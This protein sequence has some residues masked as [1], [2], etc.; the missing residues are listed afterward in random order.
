MMKVMKKIFALI[1]AML[2][3]FSSAALA[4]EI[5]FLGIPWRSSGESVTEIMAAMMPGEAPAG[6]FDAGYDPDGAWFA[7][8]G[9]EVHNVPVYMLEYNGLYDVAGLKVDRIR[10]WFVP[11]GSGGTFSDRSTEGYGLVHAE[12]NFIEDGA[13]DLKEECGQ[14]EKKLKSIYG[15]PTDNLSG[16]AAGDNFDADYDGCRWVGDNHTTVRLYYSSTHYRGGTVNTYL[17][18]SYG[19]GDRQFYMNKADLTPAE[20]DVGPVNGL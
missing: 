18:I 9:R 13:A 4:D 5:C 15:E 3:L 1:A 14:L 16:G 8:G 19:Y 12:Y 17:T 10:L 7:D 6:Q 2:I 20:P 11:E